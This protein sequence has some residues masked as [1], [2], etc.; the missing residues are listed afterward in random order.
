VG[1]R[2]AVATCSAFPQLTDDDPLLLEALR[3]RGVSGEPAVWDDPAV[4]WGAHELVVIRSTWDYT[5]RH[6]E[7]V[8]WADAVPRLLNAAEVIRWNTGKRY[9]ASVAR[10]VPT[11]FVEPRQAWEPPAGE[12]VVKPAVSAGSRDTARY[13]PGDEERAGQHVERLLLS[14]QTVMTQPYLAPVDDHGETALVFFAGEYSHAIRKGHMLTRG[15]APSSSLYLEEDI[16]PREPDRAERA[17]AEEVLDS[18]PW[19][20]SELLYAR[21]DLIRGPGDQ[22]C[23]IELELTEPSLFLSYAD[24]AAEQLAARVLERL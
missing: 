22:P 2:V 13:G 24:G 19:P 1:A 16:R 15:R 4:D 6:A 11:R 12:Y 7:F 21:V 5:D 3:A 18:L 8:A 14:G 17:A 23:L 9:L 20:R 10:A